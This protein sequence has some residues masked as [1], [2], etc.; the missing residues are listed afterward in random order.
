MARQLIEALQ[1]EFDPMQF[2]DEYRK[3]VQELVEAKAAGE[4]PRLASMPKQK[5]VESLAD[6]LEASLRAAK[7]SAA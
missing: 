1:D 6:A 5:K 7:R 3:R 2:N 4:K